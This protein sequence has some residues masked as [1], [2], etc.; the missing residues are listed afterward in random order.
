MVLVRLG[1]TRASGFEMK[2]IACERPMDLG[3]PLTRWSVPDLPARHTVVR[4]A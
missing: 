2:R 1:R 4:P 3:V